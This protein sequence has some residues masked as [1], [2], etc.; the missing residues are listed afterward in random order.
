MCWVGGYEGERA[1]SLEAGSAARKTVGGKGFVAKGVVVAQKGTSSQVDTT[2]GWNR[3]ESTKWRLPW[4]RC[5]LQGSGLRVAGCK[6]Q[7]LGLQ[8][9][10]QNATSQPRDCKDDRKQRALL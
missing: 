3:R 10:R 1:S 9:A 5:R 2:K 4:R 6:V 8:A 7:A